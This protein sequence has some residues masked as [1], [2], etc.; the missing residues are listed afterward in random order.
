M[1]LVS[2]SLAL[3]VAALAT[4][5]VLVTGIPGALSPVT[6]ASEATAYVVLAI[7]CRLYAGS[8]AGLLGA[9]GRPGRLLSAASVS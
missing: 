5:Q 3:A 4:G 8:L 9:A 7:V 2:T 6:V 1:W